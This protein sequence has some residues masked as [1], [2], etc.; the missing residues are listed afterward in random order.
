MFR[1]LGFS[2]TASHHPAGG[3]Q[4]LPWSTISL[5]PEIPGDVSSTPCHCCTARHLPAGGDQPPPGF[6]ISSGQL[7]WL[8]ASPCSYTSAPVP[9]LRSRRFSCDL[10]RR[11]HLMFRSGFQLL[12]T[13]LF[14]L[15]TC[16]CG[17]FLRDLLLL[18]D[19]LDPALMITSYRVPV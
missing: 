2:W 5:G 11:D 3:G 12:R 19:V 6:T 10:F 13:L 15:Q 4:F 1:P 7:C 9:L 17:L 8:Y 16:H 14:A 18:R